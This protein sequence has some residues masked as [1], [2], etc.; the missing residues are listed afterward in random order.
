MAKTKQTKF[1]GVKKFDKDSED[2]PL[3][4][5]DGVN[6]YE[7]YF[8]NILNDPMCIIFNEYQ[9]FDI[10]NGIID[11]NRLNRDSQ[12]IAYMRYYEYLCIA[13]FKYEYIKPLLD[14]G[15]MNGIDVF[16]M[17]KHSLRTRLLMNIPSFDVII[18]PEFIFKTVIKYN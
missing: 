15:N 13:R 8:A 1:K 14:N 17:I 5:M 2:N 16:Q 10:F 6:G 3:L 9:E 11:V 18:E 4:K 12:I 7:M